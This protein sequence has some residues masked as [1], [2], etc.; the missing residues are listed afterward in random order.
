MSL[1]S[2]ASKRLSII[3]KLT[4]ERLILHLRVSNSNKK[5]QADYRLI[6]SHSLVIF[7]PFIPSQ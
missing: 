5:L 1:F 4:D 3:Y 2:S 6:N 7:V